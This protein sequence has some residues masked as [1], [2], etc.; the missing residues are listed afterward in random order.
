ML[1]SVEVSTVTA[2][3]VLG[4]LLMSINVLLSV[5]KVKTTISTRGNIGDEYRWAQPWLNTSTRAPM[6]A[7]FV[8]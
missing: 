3:A 7:P 4:W 6:G 1:K 5:T 2:S 8:I